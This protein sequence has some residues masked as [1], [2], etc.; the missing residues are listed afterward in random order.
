[1]K[2][3]V[4]SMELPADVGR[5]INKVSSKMARV[6]A[7]EWKTWTLVFS[8]PAFLAASIP[9]NVISL[10]ATYVLSMRKLLVAMV[11]DDAILEGQFCERFAAVFGE[12]FATYNMHAH[13][14]LADTL[15]QIGSLQTV[16][17]FAFE[18]L[19]G[20]LGDTPTNKRH[21]E[22]QVMRVH[23]QLGALV[24]SAKACCAANQ[25]SR[26]DS[27]TSALTQLSAS[28]SGSQHEVELDLRGR[29]NLLRQASCTGEE[30]CKIAL[31]EKWSTTM[32]FSDSELADRTRYY[33]SIICMLG[34]SLSDI[35]SYCYFAS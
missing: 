19:N 16:R 30:P 4:D 17:C 20:V 9:D 13:L 10:W 21:S 8:I 1:M 35:C 7:A 18:R 34:G 32:L 11:H 14:H 24:N 15:S 29:M 31:D 12:K 6:T 22:V 5:I 2:V 28:S 33:T 23:K 26:V 27:V 25:A 3:V